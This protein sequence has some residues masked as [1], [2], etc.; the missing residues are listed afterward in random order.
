ML[1][2]KFTAMLSCF[3]TEC[4]LPAVPQSGSYEISEDGSD[5]SFSCDTGF[6]LKGLS[7]ITCMKDG[8]GFN[9][10]APECGMMFVFC[11]IFVYVSACIY[12]HVTAVI[13]AKLFLN[14]SM[15]LKNAIAKTF[16]PCHEKT[17]FNH[18]RTTKV[19]ISLPIRAAWSAPLLFTA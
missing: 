1:K 6:T 15:Y 8:S 19:Q 17:C 13:A 10:S 4:N 16:E 3:S 7:Q 11:K 14:S 9:A 5:I 12:M 2:L 18:M